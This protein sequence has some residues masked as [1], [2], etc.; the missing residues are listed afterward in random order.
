MLPGIEEDIR[1]SSDSISTLA[2][3]NLTLVNL[4]EA[5]LFG[6]IRASIQRS[7]KGPGMENS[8]SKVGSPKT[9]SKTIRCKSAFTTTLGPGQLKHCI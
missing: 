6:D 3:D 9:E 2:S 7:T 1:T 5:D 4:E 8:S